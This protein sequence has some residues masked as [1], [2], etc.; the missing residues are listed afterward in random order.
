VAEIDAATTIEWSV[1]AVVERIAIE[2]RL[3]EASLIAV[4]S[5]DESV[6]DTDAVREVMLVEVTEIDDV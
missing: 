1:F 5:G 6:T 2:Y 4:C 3:P